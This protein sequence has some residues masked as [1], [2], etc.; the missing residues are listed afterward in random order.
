MVN[1][2]VEFWNAA[3]MTS[4]REGMPGFASVSS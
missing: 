4:L 1:Y 3:G 2:T